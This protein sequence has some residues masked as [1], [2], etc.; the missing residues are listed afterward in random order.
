MVTIEHLGNI[1]CLVSMVSI[2]H[3]KYKV[4]M[5]IEHN[6]SSEHGVNWIEQMQHV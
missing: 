1:T 3:L 6:M 5:E 2:G 4:S